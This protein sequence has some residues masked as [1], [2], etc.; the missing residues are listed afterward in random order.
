[1]EYTSVYGAIKIDRDYENSVAFIRSIG[2]GDGFPFITTNMF[3]L[4]DY[5]RPYYYENMLITFG[6]TYKYFGMDLTD[7]NIFILKIENILRNIDFE[8]AK[9]HVD[10][11]IND[12][13]LYWMSK[14]H[15]DEYWQKE[16]RGEEYKLI[17]TDDF[18][19]GFGDRDLITALPDKRYDKKYDE[20]HIE[21]FSYP[22][23]FSDEVYQ[24]VRTFN[25]KMKDFQIGSR[26]IFQDVMDEDVDDRL[27]EFFYVLKLKGIYELAYHDPKKTIIVLKKHVDI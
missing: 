24:K 11:S 7:W 8:S 14:K 5:A 17:E 23:K 4:G 16:Y 3:G 12:C 20:I 10:G 9:F 25:G 18:F 2:E 27:Y 13:V 22:I 26:V 1:M 15:S 6:A 19:F 21:G